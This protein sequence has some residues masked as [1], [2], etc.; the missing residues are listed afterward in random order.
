MGKGRNR[1]RQR[2]R[3]IRIK[4]KNDVLFRLFSGRTHSSRLAISPI[5]VYNFMK[6][7]CL[8]R[9]VY[10]LTFYIFQLKFT[11]GGKSGSLL[12]L[13]EEIVFKIFILVN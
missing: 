4:I 13:S 12:R 10:N 2:I 3:T 11:I 8:L 9:L 5:T 1:E 7:I 6:L